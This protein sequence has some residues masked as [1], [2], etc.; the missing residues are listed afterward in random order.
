MTQFDWFL[1]A[2][3]FQKSSFNVSIGMENWH[4]ASK[5]SENSNYTL[6]PSQ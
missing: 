1:L 5:P 6:I 2:V 3:T 4:I